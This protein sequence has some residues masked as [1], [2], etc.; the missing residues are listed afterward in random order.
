MS[1]ALVATWHGGDDQARRFWRQ[2]LMLLMP[3]MHVTAVTFEADGPRTFGDIVVHY[4]PHKPASGPA[5]GSTSGS[6]RA[7]CE[8]FQI[9]RRGAHEERFTYESQ[10]DPSFINASAHSILQ[11]LADAKKHGPA[12]RRAQKVPLAASSRISLSR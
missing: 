12:A 4:E 7:P 10:T 2:A 11:R 1:R 8:Y 3:N 9:K 6:T 5:S